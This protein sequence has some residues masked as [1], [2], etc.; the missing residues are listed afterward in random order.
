MCRLGGYY[1]KQATG[2]NKPKYQKH[3]SFICDLFHL[4]MK[5]TTFLWFLY[6]TS[7]T[8]TFRVYLFTSCVPGT[9]CNTWSRCWRTWLQHMVAL[10]L[11][12][13]VPGDRFRFQLQ[14]S[15]CADKRSSQESWVRRT[16]KGILSC[17]PWRKWYTRDQTSVHR[18][19]LSY[20]LFKF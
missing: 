5:Q 16:R 12:P 10:P 18:Y 1:E 11:L 14:N 20:D 4:W 15:H 8:T 17:L 6:C 3:P 9:H 7:L 13:D 2:D 19:F